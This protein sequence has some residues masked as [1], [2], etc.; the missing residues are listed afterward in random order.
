MGR[1]GD[2]VAGLATPLQHS[3][4]L[5]VLIDR[6]GDARVVML[7]EAS[8]GSH[9]FYDWRS[10]ITQRLI[11]ELGFTFVAVEGDWPDC[12][13]VDQSVRFAEDAD[14]R[15]ALQQYR[16]WPTWMWANE[17]VS[18]FSRWL[19]GHNEFQEPA[20]R[21]GFHGLDVY[22]LWESLDEILIHLR[23]RHPELVPLGLDAFH[24]FEPFVDQPQQYA[25]S[26]HTRP[27]GCSCE[28]SGCWPPCAA[29]TTSTPGRTPR[30]WPGPSTTTGRWSRAARPRGTCVTGTWTRRW[31]GCWTLR[32]A[33]QGCGL[34]A[35]HSRGR[36]VG[37]GDGRTGRDHH[38]HAGPAALR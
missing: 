35:Q 24:C 28:V 6:V 15:E 34:G 18:D 13:R 36:R 29:R 27:A 30:W 14:P 5:N 38:R 1:Y 37:F 9:E 12:E 3:E 10:R 11:Q 21:V 33:V 20:R 25:R 22:S 16:R 17:E 26:I 8:H 2:E 4:D 23:E 7:G 31:P 19:R 32:A